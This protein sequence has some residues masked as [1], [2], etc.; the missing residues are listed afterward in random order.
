MVDRIT[1]PTITCVQPLGARS[2]CRTRRAFS[3]LVQRQDS[4][5]R[6]G[7]RER[8][9]SAAVMTKLPHL[10]ELSPLAILERCPYPDGHP[11]RDLWLMAGG[12]LTESVYRGQADLLDKLPDA[13][14]D[15]IK[16][17]LVKA[18]VQQFDAG[19]S[20]VVKAVHDYA[21]ASKFIDAMAQRRDQ[22]VTRFRK[23]LEQEPMPAWVRNAGLHER[24]RLRL[25]QRVAHWTAEA[26]AAIRRKQVSS[27][28]SPAPDHPSGAS[29][30]GNDLEG[31]IAETRQRIEHRNQHLTATPI[32]D[33]IEQTDSAPR[34]IGGFELTAYDLS[35]AE[36]RRR[37]I[38][39]YVKACTQH[40]GQ[41]VYQKHIWQFIRHK[42]SRTFQYWLANDL[43]KPSAACDEAVRRVLQMAPETF[44]EQLR[45]R[46]LLSAPERQEPTAE[47]RY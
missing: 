9:Q 26:F 35:T 38:A 5:R 7:L 28:D 40:A 23:R 33:R 16:A 17:I 32:S 3:R 37:A 8:S 20:I 4:P 11:R 6:P 34:D 15:E 10:D 46:R 13:S 41:P 43:D 45:A 42:T 1:R 31:L 39:D 19:F 21:T 14:N 22:D 24:L 30:T 36:G 27:G 47:G 18:S 2:P 44:V 25:N 12:L 29:T